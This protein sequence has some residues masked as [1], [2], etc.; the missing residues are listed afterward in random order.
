[1]SNNAH[2]T[3]PITSITIDGIQYALDNFSQEIK[4]L[5]A[6]YHV[7]QQEQQELQLEKLKLDAAL[8]FV[9][10]DIMERASK[11]LADKGKI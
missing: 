10:R 4:Q 5:I 7:W 9:Q 11:E 2:Q 8:S 1:M 3:T 6:V